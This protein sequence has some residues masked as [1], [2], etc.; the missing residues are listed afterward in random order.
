[1]AFVLHRPPSPS[2]RESEE[3]VLSAA[4]HAALQPFSTSTGLQSNPYHGTQS[5]HPTYTAQTDEMHREKAEK[6]HPSVDIAVNSDTL[7]LR[8]TGVDVEPAL[9]SGNVVLHLSEATSIKEITLQFRGK[10]RI[11]PSANES[12]ALNSSPLT[13]VVC[14]HEWSFLEGTK[15]HAHT[16]KA[17][18]HL[19]PFQL[20]IGGS[21]P[22][23]IGTTALGGASV[24]YKLRAT[25]VRPYFGLHH[26]DLHSIHPIHI[27][28]GF[29]PEALEYQQTLEIENTWPEKLMYSIM[30]P[31][32][33]WAA[34]DRVTAVVKFSPLVKGARVQ[35]VTTMIN[36]TVKLFGRAGGCQET[37]RTIATT[38][39]DFHGARAVCVDEQHHRFR[40]P[41]LHHTAQSH[42]LTGSRGTSTPAS[43]L[44]TNSGSSYFPPQ[45]ATHSPGEMTPLTTV[46][47]NSSSSS[48]SAPH[49]GPSAGASSSSI[50]ISPISSAPESEAHVPIGIELPAELEEE[51]SQDVVTTLHISVPLH[52]TP[53]HALE[54]IQVSHRIRWS[55]MIGNLDGHT[56][57]LR[58]SLPLHLLD[59]RLYDEAHSATLQTRRLLLG[60]QDV[61]G[62]QAVDTHGEASDN[63]EDME[64][65]SYPAHVRDRVANAYLPDTGIM[66]VTNPWIAQ[67]ISPVIMTEP[68]TESSSGLQS[69]APLECFQINGAPPAQTGG[70]NPSVNPR[71]H[72]PQV[73]PP[74]AQQLHWVNS[75]LLLSM[76]RQ[77]DQLPASQTWKSVPKS[78]SQQSEQSIW[79]SGEKFERWS[80]RA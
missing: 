22:S 61:E 67:G 21:L 78:A 64:L 43:P 23:S 33:A 24:H 28:R 12:L 14:N 69:P 16:L 76:T 65:P 4:L 11:P 18:R 35:N 26:R 34:G 70:S 41:L 20:H 60:A 30:V 8:G 40:V 50:G 44:Q 49:A 32:K 72:L 57:E 38:K 71:N 77:P 5:P 58:C 6:G 7:I 36:E 3:D 29:S 45:P 46:T 79:Q 52:A 55:I 68:R 48:S 75:E 53:A 27:V 59:H 73:P 51:P 2:P 39:H 10:A 80:F 63:E 74:D 1:M 56:S 15:T 42:S 17:G 31:H 37:T 66:R 47:T 62:G 54:P 19:F 25:V 9:L 13:Y